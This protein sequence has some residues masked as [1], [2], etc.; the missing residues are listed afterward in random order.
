MVTKRF[1]QSFDLLRARISQRLDYFW[2]GLLFAA[3]L[4]VLLSTS[5]VRISGE[6]E[7]YFRA[8]SLYSQWFRELG[9]HLIAG[10]LFRSFSQE[11]ID[12]Y[13]SYRSDQ[14]VVMKMLFALSHMLFHE[15]LGWMQASTAYRLPTMV[16]AAGLVSS[17]FLFGAELGRKYF[18]SSRFAYLFGVTAAGALLLQPQFFRESHLATLNIPLVAL[19]FA[20]IYAYWRSFSSQNWA[21]ATGALFG[22]ALSVEFRALYL[23]LLLGLH[24]FLLSFWEF[25]LRRE[26]TSGLVLTYPQ[27]KSA[28]WAMLVGGPLLFYTLWPRLWFETFERTQGYFQFH[29]HQD[30]SASSTLQS[31]LLFLHT[32][33]PT[34]L[35][36]GAVGLL[37]LFF[38]SQIVPRTKEATHALRKKQWPS[39]PK[40]TDHRGLPLLLV[41]SLLFP[42]FLSTAGDI[43]ASL[44]TMPFL[45]L[46]GGWA[47]VSLVAQLQR[48]LRVWDRE[49]LT[50]LFTLL[51]PLL[52]L[53]PA[54]IE[55]VQ[56]HPM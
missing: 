56:S 13:F 37:L 17:L 41:L 30:L 16:I 9:D 12:R 43:N 46:I 40:T 55:T 44:L 35:F 47:V 34:L 11:S 48:R 10:D 42:L 50:P 22:L 7:V 32:V 1:Y 26:G 54:L 31:F 28:L 27:I 36:A 18:Q 38:D 24:W 45:A 19:W 51:F 15:T 21:V 6:E 2:A 52:L 23:P 8:A 53:L 49:N 14:P 20:V 25:R 39:P 3:T 4:I 29:L 33:P 5:Q